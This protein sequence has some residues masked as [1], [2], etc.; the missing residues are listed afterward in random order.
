M[1]VG[2]ER[3]TRQGGDHAHKIGPG[4][5]GSQA[6]GDGIRIFL[7]ALCVEL[8]DGLNLGGHP[9]VEQL[10]SQTSPFRAR[11]GHANGPQGDGE[12]V[13]ARAGQLLAGEERGR[14]SWQAPGSPRSPRVC[15]RARGR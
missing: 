2:A 4:E 13:A 5:G 14:S 3:P 1:L 7:P 6:T 15:F 9:R 11:V 10:L 8:T 12:L